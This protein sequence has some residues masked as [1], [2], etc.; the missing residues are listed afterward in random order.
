MDFS[1]SPPCILAASLCIPLL[2]DG[3]NFNSWKKRMSIFI[4][5]YDIELWKVIVLGP[6]IP[7]NNDGTLKKYEHF[8]NED[9]K[10][11]SQNAKTTQ[12]LYCALSPKE[13]N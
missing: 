13:Y 12:L 8:N 6:K 4:Q 3:S 7:K 1:P 10:S 11:L 2:F 9:W 5:S